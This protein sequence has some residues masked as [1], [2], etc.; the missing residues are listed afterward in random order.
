LGEK[1]GE[2]ALVLDKVLKGRLLFKGM[3]LNLPFYE[4][5]GDGSQCMQVAM[6]IVLKHFLN[7]E[8]SLEELD[9]LT[10]RKKGKWTSTSQIVSALYDLG[11]DVK[12]YS[13]ED[14]EPFLEGEPFIRKHYGKD[15]DK[16]L[17]FI[18]L[19]VVIDS[20]KNLLNYSVFEKKK[21]DF[22]EIEEHMKKGRVPLMLIDHNKI[23]G[24]DDKYQG[25]FVVVTGFG[26]ESVYY[27]ES[28]P[29]APEP[30]KNVPKSKFIEA[31]NANGTD[32]DTVIVYGRRG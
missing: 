23:T 4:N 32:N 27:H 25:H 11:L 9:S 29:K 26:E 17:K 7:K 12:F 8:Y 24:K 20:I 2:K 31:L 28:G 6:Q 15:A 10:K 16:I 3:R 22:S 18:D 19:P 30:N 21:L 14:L 1:A 13:K 5:E